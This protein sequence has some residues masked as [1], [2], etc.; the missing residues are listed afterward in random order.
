FTFTWRHGI[1]EFSEMANPLKHYDMLRFEVAKT[2]EIAAFS[3]I[4]WRLRAGGFLNNKYIT[5]Y[6]FYHINSQ[7]LPVL[8]NNYQ[9]AFMLPAFYSLSTPEFYVQ[10]HGK[11]TTPYLLLKFLPFLSNTL[12]RENLS[13][14]TLASGNH[15]VYYEVGYSLSEIFFLA[16]LGVY[17]GF[18]DLS[19]R[20]AGVSLTLKF[21]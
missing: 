4:R 18:Q 20:S 17:V 11:I 3:E 6:D 2:K 5:F 15:P 10:A 21:N 16:E 12:M 13:L 14:S 7:P 1:N 19:Y 8:L 9:D